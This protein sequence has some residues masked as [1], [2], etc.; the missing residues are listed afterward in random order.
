MSL[1]TRDSHSVGLGE[2]GQHFK[3]TQTILM[4]VAPR[5]ITLSNLQ[6]N[7]GIAAL[8]FKKNF[9]FLNLDRAD[10]LIT[11]NLRLVTIYSLYYD[12]YNL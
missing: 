12:H 4:N 5:N 7:Y 9:F 11:R 3:S 8:K 2:Q 1:S 6:A 10:I